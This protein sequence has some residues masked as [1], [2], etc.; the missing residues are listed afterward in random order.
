MGLKV[1][2]VCLGNICR[3]PTA[4]G[5]FQSMVKAQGLEDL[6]EGASIGLL[7]RIKAEL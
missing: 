5:V 2:F 6:L 4:G 3:S 1:V 7:Q